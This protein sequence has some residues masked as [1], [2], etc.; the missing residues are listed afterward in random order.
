MKKYVSP[1][2]YLVEPE[3]LADVIRT[4][5]FEGGDDEIGGGEGGGTVDTP[6]VGSSYNT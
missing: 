6:I 3:E 1:K 2:A 5:G 4:S